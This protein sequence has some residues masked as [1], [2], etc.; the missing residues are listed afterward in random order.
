MAF[1]EIRLPK[2]NVFPGQ[3][4]F[5]VLYFF[6]FSHPILPTSCPLVGEANHTHFVDR[7]IKNGDTLPD[8]G[9]IHT[10][11]CTKFQKKTP[12]IYHEKYFEKLLD[13][14]AWTS[15][16]NNW[17]NW[18][19][20]N[21][22]MHTIFLL[23]IHPIFGNHWSALLI[24]PIL[25]LLICWVGTRIRH[26]FFWT[27]SPDIIGWISGMKKKMPVIKK[28]E[29]GIHQ[30][31]ISVLYSPYTVIFMFTSCSRR[32]FVTFLSQL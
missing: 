28:N 14:V 12:V 24:H 27:N 9:K 7:E 13:P 1:S 30:F 3:M 4:S 21:G 23:L 2:K 22:T 19:E 5:G 18:R 6:Q 26:K 17:Q 8:L 25:E 10:E 11:K 31:S 16:I 29:G 15:Q 20:K 32:E